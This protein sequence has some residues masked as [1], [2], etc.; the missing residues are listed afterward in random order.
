[1]AF[2]FVTIKLL[3]GNL[4]VI[5]QVAVLLDDIIPLCWD[6]CVV[7]FRRV[8]RFIIIETRPVKD[9]KFPFCAAFKPLLVSIYRRLLRSCTTP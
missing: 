6:Y 2:Y 4:I 9:S 7:S 5:I 1:M 3:I 8:H